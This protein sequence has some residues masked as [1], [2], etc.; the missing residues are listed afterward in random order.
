MK[1]RTTRLARTRSLAVDSGIDGMKWGRPLVKVATPA[2]V[3]TDTVRMESTSNAAAACQ[4]GVA[5]GQCHRRSSASS[6]IDEDLPGC[7]P[8]DF[9][10][11]RTAPGLGGNAGGVRHDDQVGVLVFGDANDGTTDR[12]SGNNERLA[13]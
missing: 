6:R 12:S 9:G 4:K 13:G 5:A 7:A 3:L 10:D 1:S 8:Q 11:D 2:A